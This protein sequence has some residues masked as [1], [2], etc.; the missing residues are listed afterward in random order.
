MTE[1]KVQLDVYSGPLDLLLFLIRRNEIDIYDIPVAKITEQYLQYVELLRKLDPE[2]VSE[3]LVLA[4]TLLEIKSRTL[5]PRPPVDEGEATLVDPR[6]ELVRQLLEYKDFKDAAMSLESAADERAR[7]HARVAVL[8]PRDE[9]EIELDNVDIWDLFEAFN[10]LLEQ[11]GKTGPYHEVG[12]D[13]T[14]LALHAADILDSLDRAGGSQNFDEVFRGRT[15][16]EMIG[17]FLALLELVRQKRVRAVQDRPFA[18]IQLQKLEVVDEDAEAAL[19][20]RPEYHEYDRP[21]HV[22]PMTETLPLEEEELSDDESSDDDGDD[23]LLSAAKELLAADAGVDEAFLQVEPAPRK[24]RTRK[25][26]N[27]QPEE[28][29]HETQ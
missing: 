29:E 19:V 21:I 1:Y 27:D 22:S 28:M 25:P 8:P 10:R 16:A 11:T 9:S 5:L 23:E 6:A 24:R 18:A 14:P 17:L 13:D 12:V 3:F 15:R 4:A 7:Q 2:A 26:K 20:D